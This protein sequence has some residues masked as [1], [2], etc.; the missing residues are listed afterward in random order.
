MKRFTALLI[1]V[2]TLCTTTVFAHPFTDVSG[3]WAEPEIDKAYESGIV[4]GDGDG[5]FRPDDGISRAEF[6][7]MLAAVTAENYSEDIPNDLAES[8][9]WVSKYYVFA[10]NLIYEPL[11]EAEKVGNVIPG[12]LTDADVDE[13]IKRWEMAFMV[14]KAFE[15]MFY[16]TDGADYADAAQVAE[17]YPAAVAEAV[18]ICVNVGIIKGDENGNFNAGDGGT[19]A[20]AAT[21]MN[22]MDAKM[23]ELI[24]KNN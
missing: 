4:N 6:V 24:A 23:R 17:V 20:E 14:G 16:I 15:N 22:R 19:R 1:A 12:L 3:H 5:T 7:K 13:P 8:E 9:H 10:K 11:T 18:A 2:I 21:I